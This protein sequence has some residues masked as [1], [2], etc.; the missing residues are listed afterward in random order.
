MGVSSPRF[1]IRNL[2]KPL[3]G[4]TDICRDSGSSQIQW[5]LSE[6]AGSGRKKNQRQFSGAVVRVREGDMVTSESFKREGSR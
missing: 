2:E 5:Q 3:E 6:S 1:Q 4:A